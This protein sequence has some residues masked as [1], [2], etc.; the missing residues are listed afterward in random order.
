MNLRLTICTIF[1]GITLY[2]QE[3]IENTTYA[4]IKDDL[5]AALAAD[6]YKDCVRLIDKINVNDS[7]YKSLSIT[8]SYA[9]LQNKE[10]E[11]AVDYIN[12]T[13]PN[14]KGES[15]YSLLLN[16]AVSYERWGK[17]EKAIEFYD[18]LLE[19]YPKAY[20]PHYNKALVLFQDK[21][22]NKGYDI[23]EKSLFLSPFDK[24]TH[25]KM[26]ELYYVERKLSQALMSLSM[27]LFT[28]PDSQNSF[29]YLK[30]VNASF[31]RKS[32]EEA[33]GIE[34]TEDDSAFKNVDLV[35]SNGV[36]LNSKYKIKNKI[37]IP[38]V[39]QL[40]VLFEQLETLE[41]KGD[42]WDKKM[43]P[44]FK[45]IKSS[46]NFDNFIYT[47]CFSIENPSY[48]K[49]VLKNKSNIINFIIEANAKWQAIISKDNLE[50]F[51]GKNQLVDYLYDEKVFLALGKAQGDLKIGNWKV[52]N[53]EGKF[54]REGTFS[55]SGTKNGVWFSYD[56]EGKKQQQT[57]YKEGQPDGEVLEFHK[58]GKVSY[59]YKYKEGKLNGE[60]FA[61]SKNGMLTTYKVFKNDELDG[62]FKTYYALGEKTPEKSIIYKE[63]K[64]NGPYK[65]YYNTGEKYSEITYKDGV[66][67]GEEITY[68]RDGSKRSETNYVNNSLNGTYT[69]YFKNGKKANVGNYVNDT[70]TGVWKE[71][72]EDGTIL[73]EFEYDSKGKLKGS[74]KEYDIDGKLISEYLYKNGLI[75]SV[76][77][78]NKEG[79]PIYD[80]KRKS[81]KLAYKDYT[82]MSTIL[83]EGI[84]NVKGGREGS[85]KYYEN[86]ALESESNNKDGKNEG[87]TTWFFIDGKVNNK[88][89]FKND[90]KNGYAVGYYQ[91]GQ[92]EYQGYYVDGLAVGEW[93]SYYLDGTV[94]RI[95]FYHKDEIH[96]LDQNF[97]VNGKLYSEKIYEYG[98]L[99][100]ITYY[101]PD[102][103]VLEQKS[104]NQFPKKE[105]LEYKHYNNKQHT[106]YTYEG[107]VKHGECKKYHFNGKLSETGNYFLGEKHGVWKVFDDNGSLSEEATYNHGDLN[108][109][110][111]YFVNG[112]RSKVENYKNGKQQG[113]ETVYYE[114]G[115]TVK[116][117]FS[118]RNDKPHGTYKF[119]APNGK[120]QFVRYYHNDELL[121]YSYN[122]EN[123]VLKPMIPLQ[124][125]S[126]KIQAY[127][128]NGKPSADIQMKHGEFIGDYK[129]YHDNGELHRLDQH[130]SKGSSNGKDEVYYPNGTLKETSIYDSGYR[131]SVRKLYY[132]NGKVKKEINYL[133]GTLHGKASYFNVSGK[134]IK[135]RQ[136]FNGSIIEE[137]LF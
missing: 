55:E 57:N 38:L 112:K 101:K 78:F 106:V 95:R 103:S 83:N 132:P 12:K 104:F 9:Y 59:K 120:L 14:T 89:N 123:G 39:K 34:F 108:G 42:F 125:Q 73:E 11:K 8:K 51:E 107:G 22:W 56:E 4:D 60:Y 2:A 10:Y 81:G 7:I 43:I 91:N 32:K 30:V 17:K 63:G 71:F 35:L 1:M 50:N 124:N 97:A 115:K 24:D 70:R 100:K 48:K 105:K 31:S 18:N 13:L 21:Q 129:K 130:N 76:K 119:Y 72:Y 46:D 25:Y 67:T 122:D 87:E 109:K 45:W 28:N 86:G 52:Y 53:S 99:K 135:E 62:A 6:N 16:R 118:Y 44:F 75:V 47:I 113:I 114:D 110:V 36:A 58:D 29:E 131:T 61:Y 85:W 65:L 27:S 92:M 68:Y 134:K 121:G 127:F 77:H 96:G 23:L 74:Y 133:N 79:T 41:G 3:K 94:S 15:R 49:I 19:E 136:Y 66:F 93:R 117:E 116:K 33:R 20:Q 37:K 82:P 88:A 84:Y 98:E 54:I 80:A 111:E 64:L 40:T 126:G 102:G 5:T 90:E 26:G 137:K 69:T 128:E